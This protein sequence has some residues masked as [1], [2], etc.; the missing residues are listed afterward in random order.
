MTNTT[1][2]YRKLMIGLLSGEIDETGR[3]ELDAWLQA[4]RENQKVFEQYE[5]LWRL[6]PSKPSGKISDR[7]EV[8]RKITEKI[9]QIDD[10]LG[11]EKTRYIKFPRVLSL[12]AAAAVVIIIMGL[13][14]FLPKSEKAMMIS[15]SGE[16]DGKPVELS[17]GTLVY[18]KTEGT[19]VYPEIFGEDTRRVELTGDAFFEV[20]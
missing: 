4:S 10:K 19:L 2:K 20:A 16:R 17:D 12:I 18:F 8:W 3:T 6:K 9:D 5:M 7:E 15:Q 14:F 11:G 13:F 1:E